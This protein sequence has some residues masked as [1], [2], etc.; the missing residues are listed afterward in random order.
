MTRIWAE[1]YLRV[2]VEMMMGS[3]HC[4]KHC[5]IVGESQPVLTMMADPMI[6]FTR[7]TRT[8]LCDDVVRRCY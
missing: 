8:T 5:G 1:I 4:R 3:Q 7:F 2:R 6:I